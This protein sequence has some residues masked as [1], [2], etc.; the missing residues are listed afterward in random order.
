MKRSHDDSES[1]ASKGWADRLGIMDY[2]G[3][4]DEE[5]ER[6]EKRG[7]KNDEE[8]GKRVR[9]SEIVKI[10]DES[11]NRIGRENHQA[12]ECR[13]CRSGYFILPD[14]KMADAIAELI[15]KSLYDVNFA[16][17][18]QNIYEAAEK[19]RATYIEGGSADPGEWPKEQIEYHLFNCMTNYSLYCFHRIQKLRRYETVLE[20][21]LF[22]E[23]DDGAL[24]VDD[25]VLNSILKIQSQMKTLW[26]AAAEKSPS[27][28]DKISE[29]SGLRKLPQY[30]KN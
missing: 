17:L 29:H 9:F 11:L 3:D 28:N 1:V 4:P 23:K 12:N 16:D 25:K 20:D 30:K 13:A 14:N 27:Y 2:N 19:E 10:A 8:K 18:L 15:R 5:E 21:Q 6:Q 24:V 22:I 7:R 26:T